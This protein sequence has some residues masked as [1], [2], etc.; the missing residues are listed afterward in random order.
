M[1]DSGLAADSKDT[2]GLPTPVRAR[3]MPTNPAPQTE[4]IGIDD[5]QWAKSLFGLSLII[6][7]IFSITIAV[8]SLLP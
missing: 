3:T 8:T 2:L 5:I 7:I 6:L 4:T 1:L